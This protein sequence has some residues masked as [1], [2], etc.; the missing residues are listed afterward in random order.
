MIDP[1][2]FEALLRAALVD[3]RREE[4]ERV[5]LLEPPAANHQQ[6][7]GDG[8]S[9][10]KRGCSQGEAENLENEKFG[11]HDISW[12]LPTSFPRSNCTP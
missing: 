6:D 3:L 8:C 11:R 10:L 7:D 9:V 1:A 4:L 2:T 12:R 5:L